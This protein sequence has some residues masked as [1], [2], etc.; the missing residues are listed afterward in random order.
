M[1]GIVLYPVD[2]R[3]VCYLFLFYFRN[4]RQNK[5]LGAEKFSQYRAENLTEWD[6]KETEHSDRE[7]WEERIAHYTSLRE[8]MTLSHR[9]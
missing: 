7:L 2:L 5:K 8:G 4:C 3:S 9:S 6:Y 1:S